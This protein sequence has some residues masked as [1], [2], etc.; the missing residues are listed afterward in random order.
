MKQQY[1]GLNAGMHR[2]RKG[3]ATSSGGIKEVY[4]REQAALRLFSPGKPDDLF[5]K[6]QP[7]FSNLPGCPVFLY[8]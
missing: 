2:L 7:G 5:W 3:L 1:S 4:F 8:G 6:R